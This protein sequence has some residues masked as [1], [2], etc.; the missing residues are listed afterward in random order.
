MTFQLGKEFVHTLRGNDDLSKSCD[1]PFNSVISHVKTNGFLFTI[2]IKWRLPTMHNSDINYMLEI[3][4]LHS[5]NFSKGP[6]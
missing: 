5:S 2:F 6:K 1:C 3:S 4:T